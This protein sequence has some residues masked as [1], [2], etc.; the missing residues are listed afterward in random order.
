MSAENSDGT[1]DGRLPT[2]IVPYEG[3]CPALDCQD[4]FVYLRPETN[5]VRVESILFRVIHDNAEYKSRVSLVYLANIPGD[6]IVS[7]KIVEEHYAAKLFFTVKGKSVFTGWMK[8]RFQD[9]FKVSFEDAQLLGAFEALEVLGMTCDELFRL[10]VPQ[11]SMLVLNGQSIKSY[12][13]YYILNYDLPAVL[14]RNN[15]QT[16]VAVMIFRTNLSFEGIH[17]MISRMGEALTRE[18]ILH[19]EKPLSRVFHYSKGPFEQVLDAIGYLYRGD[20]S[21]V[22]LNDLTFCR[23]LLSKGMTLEEIIVLI[24][25]P[26]MRFRISP[27]ETREEDIFTFTRD[28]SFSEAY[29]SCRSAVWRLSIT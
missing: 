21:H 22:P 18:D 19:P 6:F 20:G 28:Q 10:R 1:G 2:V 14:H 25:N 3:A 4:I 5:G 24:K 12:R 23:Y 8:E 13:G 15:N 9:Y 17:L 26:V 16:D 27:S 11:S 29:G 7:R